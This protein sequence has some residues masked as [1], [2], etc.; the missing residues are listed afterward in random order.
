MLAAR[1]RQCAVTAADCAQAGRGCRPDLPCLQRKCSFQHPCAACPAPQ[2]CWELCGWAEP[3]VLCRLP[4]SGAAGLPVLP[5]RDDLEAAAKG[6]ADVR[7]LLGR[8]EGVAR[9][10]LLSRDRPHRR[11]L[12]SA[13]L[14]GVRNHSISGLQRFPFLAVRGC[15]MLLVA[16]CQVT[17]CVRARAGLAHGWVLRASC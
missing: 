10:A 8:E 6:T 5:G 12:W 1:L 2:G 11:C 16:S 7:V 13:S 15:E 4:D 17:A 9:A 3:P 14:T